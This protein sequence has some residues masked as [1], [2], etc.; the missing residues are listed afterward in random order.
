[1]FSRRRIQDK[2]HS[3]KK[4]FLQNWTLFKASRIGVVGLA[5]MIAF[6]LIALT[7][8]FMGLRDPLYWL[9]PE[10]DT[11]S[12][13]QWW[14]MEVKPGSPIDPVRHLNDS[15]DH[16]IA[17][18]IKPGGDDARADRIY[19]PEGRFLYAINT[20]FQAY[21]DPAWPPVCFP[22]T[23]DG[24]ISVDPVIVNYGSIRD[25]TQA[26]P[27]LMLGTQN[28]TVYVM[29]DDILNSSCP[30]TRTKNF[31]SPITG[32][33]GESV[34]PF[35]GTNDRDSFVV[36]TADGRLFA[37]TVNRTAGAFYQELWNVTLNPARPA[38][39][40]IAGAVIRTDWP[41]PTSSPA[42]FQSITDQLARAGESVFV[43]DESGFLYAVRMSD[44]FVLWQ[45]PLLFDSGARWESAPVVSPAAELVP[46]KPTLV[47]AAV[48]DRESGENI[49]KV[50]VL[51]AETG[52]P[53]PSWDATGDGGRQIS[54]RGPERAVLTTPRAAGTNIY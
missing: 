10:S 32:L 39:I 33:A 47:Y 48:Q 36:G 15:V 49:S 53:P 4:L 24:A 5:I 23:T 29:F 1:M 34:D 44:G 41:I 51:Y 27:L 35:T 11:N 37:Y 17:F 28:G 12:V 50:Y 40:H 6:L 21:G 46:A 19:V 30:V 52:V 42:F 14:P 8:P 22:F 38:P 25:D 20:Y 2:Y 16:A 43:G 26:I 45:K 9:A 3:W 7:V 31:G 54:Y 13:R 18:R